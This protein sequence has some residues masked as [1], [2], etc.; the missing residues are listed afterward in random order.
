MSAPSV[1][2]PILR[3][4]NITIAV[5]DLAKVSAWY[6]SVIGFCVV[7][8]GTF[9]SVGAEF[10]MLDGVGTRI[11]LVSRSNPRV[12]SDRTEPP[13]HLDV[14]GFKA[15]VLETEELSSLTSNFEALGV[16]IVWAN[17]PISEH[18]RSTM[19][20]DPEGNLINIFGP[21]MG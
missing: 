19:I 11:E 7:E 20:R 4:D 15:L 2:R 3:F 5:A 12:L 8:R 13:A 17:A 6:T 1:D 16:E 21:R 18:R 14:L 9:P 10:V